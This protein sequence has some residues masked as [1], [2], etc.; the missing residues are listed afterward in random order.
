MK[1]PESTGPRAGKK[2]RHVVNKISSALV[3][4]WLTVLLIVAP[5]LVLPGRED[6]TEILLLVAIAA[7][8]LVFVEYLS[9]YPGL[10]EFSSAPPFNRI[11]YLMLLG[12]LLALASIIGGMTH[13]STL[14]RMVAA[15]GT[16]VAH[17][18]DMPFSPI[19]LMTAA[20]PEASAPLV[21][22]LS[23]IAFLLS[24]LGIAVFLATARFLGW[25]GKRGFNVW[26]NLPTF[27][28]T[29]SF[30]VVARMRRDARVNVILGITLPFVIPQIVI[31]AAPV[32][33]PLGPSAPLTLIWIVAAW[34]FLP[35]SLLMRAM[36]LGLV[37]GMI[38]AKRNVGSALQPA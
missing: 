3:R 36:G 20:V 12:T 9:V 26:T 14:T 8:V 2:K 24:L 11:R 18:V 33:P 23:G 7:G 32:L 28:P 37:A 1:R 17:A 25:P 29:A 13:P 16:L 22:A 15:I 19:R 21:Q 35:A 5:A 4:A 6:G 27:E 34:A 38:D 10:M 30:D 31:A